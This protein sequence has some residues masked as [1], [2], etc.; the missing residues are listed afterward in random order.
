MRDPTIDRDF[1]CNCIMWIFGGCFLYCLLENISFFPVYI[2]H[3][4]CLSLVLQLRIKE[5][6]LHTENYIIGRCAVPVSTGLAVLIALVGV[7]ICLLS[8][9]F[10]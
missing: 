4:S 9:P 6:Q 3:V 5:D 2:C 7:A 10:A 8:L 1:V